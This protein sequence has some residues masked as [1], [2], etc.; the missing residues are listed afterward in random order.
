M[1]HAQLEPAP[2]TTEM[3]A[4]PRAR[5]APPLGPA[6]SGPHLGRPVGAGGTAR[7]AHSSRRGSLGRCPGGAG[8]ARPGPG[9]SH[10]NA[11]GRRAGPGCA[12]PATPGRFRGDPRCRSP[13][14]A[15]REALSPVP[16]SGSY[17]WLAELRSRSQVSFSKPSS[18]ERAP[19]PWVLP[20]VLEGRDGSVLWVVSA[21][22]GE[23]VVMGKA[24]Q[25]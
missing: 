23:P 11:G 15:G 2:T 6:P 18:Y 5:L 7:S 13:D 12:G 4:P 3:Q 25:R 22:R 24:R 20:A 8:P 9:C 17:C 10:G 1:S 21:G 19:T 14:C 16:G